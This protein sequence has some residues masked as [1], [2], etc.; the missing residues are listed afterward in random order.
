MTTSAARRAVS[1]YLA[2]LPPAARRR[3]RQ[4]RALIA[5]A[6]P[7]AVEQFERGTPAFALDGRPLL[8]YAASGRHTSLH[9]IGS[10]LLRAHEIY[11]SPR[12]LRKATLRLPLSKPLP[13]ALI[14]Y[15]VKARVA[16]I[17]ARASKR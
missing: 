2:V 3:V 17:R 15:L 9:P 12:E 8:R 5:A 4:M 6:A 1:A 10:A 7:G 14:K 13:A 16:E 11:L